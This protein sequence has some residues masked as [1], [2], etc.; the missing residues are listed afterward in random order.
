MKKVISFL[1]LTLLPFLSFSQQEE[2]EDNPTV[3][4]VPSPQ[5]SQFTK[6]GGQEINESSGRAMVSIPLYSYKAGLLDLPISLSYSGS[7]VKVNDPNTWTGVNWS[8]AAGGVINRTVYHQPDEQ[9][10]RVPVAQVENLLDQYEQQMINQQVSEENIDASELYSYYNSATGAWDTQPD[11]FAYSFPGHSGSFFFDKNFL[12]VSLNPE[13]DLKIEITGPGVSNKENFYQNKEIKITTPEGVEYFFGGAA[14]ESSQMEYAHHQVTSPLAPTGFFLHRIEHPVFG[15]IMFQYD[16]QYYELDLSFSQYAQVYNEQLHPIMDVKAFPIGVVSTYSNPDINK[17]RIFNGQFLKRIFSNNHNIEITFNSNST[18]PGGRNFK[19]VLQGITVKKGL[20]VLRQIDFTYL[21]DDN[22]DSTVDRFFLTKLQFNKDFMPQTSQGSQNFEEY[23]FHY[24]DPLGLPKRFSYSQDLFGYYNGKSNPDGFLPENDNFRVSIYGKANRETSVA[25]I[26]KGALKKVEY[27]TGG[28]TL[29]EY[30]QLQYKKKEYQ[31]YNREIYR[32]I[33]NRI[34]TSSL[35]ASFPIGG[36]NSSVISQDFTVHYDI[37]ASSQL[38]HDDKIYLKLVNADTGIEEETKIIANFTQNDMV[39][40]A[41]GK[42]HLTGSV[43]FSVQTG[44]QYNIFFYVPTNVHSTPFEGNIWFDMEVGDV[45]TPGIGIRVKRVSD[46]VSTTDTNPV[47]KRYYYMPK[48]NIGDATLEMVDYFEEPSFIT[49]PALYVKR[50]ACDYTCNGQTDGICGCTESQAWYGCTPVPKTGTRLDIWPVNYDEN[51]LTTYEHV[52][53]SYGGDNFENGGVERIYNKGDVGYIV[54]MIHESSVPRNPK[55]EK[56]HFAAPWVDFM[57]GKLLKETKIKRDKDSL[58]VA[59]IIQHFYRKQIVDTI[60][61]SV[62]TYSEICGPSASIPLSSNAVGRYEVPIKRV[63]L[64]S[65]ETRTFLN[66]EPSIYEEGDLNAFAPLLTKTEYEYG[67]VISQPTVIKN[68]TSE[69][70]VKR[71][72][73][74]FYVANASET[75]INFTNAEQTAIDILEDQNRLNEL[76]LSRSFEERQGQEKQLNSKK[77]T[78]AQMDGN[79]FP[80]NI[81]SSKGEDLLETKYEFLAY[82]DGRPI[83][84][85]KIG[86][87]EVFV[88]YNNMGQVTKK[89]EN[90]TGSPVAAD[91]QSPCFA[92]EEWPE[93]LVT[94][95]HYDN[96][97]NLLTKI[98]GPDCRSVSYEYDDLQRLKY[99]RDHEGNIVKEYNYN[100]QN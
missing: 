53:I 40:G 62:N 91:S 28:H 9:S 82:S 36:L 60:G 15:I 2:P 23:N 22:G 3:I 33:S 92:Q 32:N 61:G 78:F 96:D 10:E 43:E 20:S 11:I 6:Y 80:A 54:N 37:A 29:F 94:V 93:S 65:V 51:I 26:S 47:I 66:D 7:G 76:L 34:P 8:V 84:I 74:N 77:I 68:S 41:D 31:R 39:A 87:P 57:K 89:I 13:Q 12:P 44:D 83:R 42:L 55:V 58:R 75:A 56:T 17:N 18:I 19:R 71:I 49:E 95:Y 50:L 73:K 25:H 46:Y 5:A 99:I 70:D 97:T 27:P 14:V 63:M 1:V 48:E 81:Q 90:Y 16:S 35:S 79:V 86:G 67:D 24:D 64:S 52:V 38:A 4:T 85:K 30:E 100:Y 98:V 21:F 88:Q 59:Q 72:T 45:L 69:T